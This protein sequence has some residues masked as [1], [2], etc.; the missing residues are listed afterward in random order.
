MISEF[1]IGT[2]VMY[3]FMF[4]RGK[5]KNKKITQK[6]DAMLVGYMLMAVGVLIGKW[7]M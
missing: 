6:V 2:M 5:I 1:I 4:L 3:M 7:L